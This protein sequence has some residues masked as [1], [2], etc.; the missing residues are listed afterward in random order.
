MLF[1]VITRYEIPYRRCLA[2]MTPLPLRA[3]FPCSRA[4]LSIAPWPTA[5]HTPVPSPTG[6]FHPPN[7]SPRTFQ[8]SQVPPELQQRHKTPLPATLSPPGRFF[9][10]LCPAEGAA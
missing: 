7:F 8:P 2:L 1:D 9:A 10:E 6:S 4:L 3:T 5:A